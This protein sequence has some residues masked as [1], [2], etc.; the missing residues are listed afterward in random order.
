MFKHFFTL[1]NI[2]ENKM[3]YLDVRAF[4]FCS[5]HSGE[6]HRGIKNELDKHS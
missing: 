6:T 2:A 5:Q 4:F 3:G 1:I